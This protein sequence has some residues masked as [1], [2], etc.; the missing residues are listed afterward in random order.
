[1][2]LTGLRIKYITYKNLS[3]LDSAIILSY[4]FSLSTCQC[5]PNTSNAS[6]Q[7]RIL[8][9]ENHNSYNH[10]MYLT[11][12]LIKFSQAYFSC[13]MNSRRKEIKYLI[14]RNYILMIVRYIYN[15]T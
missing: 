5:I 15:A 6:V 1:M 10:Y 7:D 14:F 11:T 12:I 13:D 3:Y 9:R 2:D 4:K 8:Y